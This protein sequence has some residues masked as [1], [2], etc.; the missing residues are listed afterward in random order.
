M[1]RTPHPRNRRPM[2]LRYEAQRQLIARLLL[3]GWTA[4]RIGKRLGCTSRSVRYAISAP[5]F[6][7]IFERLQQEQL[8]TLDRKMSRLL[9]SAVKT[10]AKMLKHKNTKTGSTRTV[11]LSML[12]GAL[13]ALRRRIARKRMVSDFV[14]PSRSGR[15]LTAKPVGRQFRELLRRA[16]LP[17][18][19]L[20]DLRHT[21][22]THLLT[23]N[24]NAMPS[25]PAVPVAE[26]ARVMGHKKPTTTWNFYAHAIPGDDMQYIDR[27]TAARDAVRGRN[28]DLNGDIAKTG[29]ARTLK[30][31]RKMK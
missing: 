4:E 24:P 20:Y 26:V 9:H 3:L 5:K 7:E 14:F 11:R 22:A 23:G 12:I 31:S 6:Q 8:K 18:F 2:R 27:L 30:N 16:G 28:G 19:K 17:K 15:A 21:F 10:L 1:K 25:V 13:E 29:S